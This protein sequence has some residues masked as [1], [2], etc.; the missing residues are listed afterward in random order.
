M[1]WLQF[2]IKILGVNFHNSILDSSNWHK[3]KEGA[4]RKIHIWNRVRLSLTV[5]KI[6]V[7]QILLSKTWDIR[8]I[9][10]ISKYIKKNNEIRSYGFI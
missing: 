5:N 8:Q 2:F 6:I 10:T 1:E 7:N 4:I 3:I 9:Y